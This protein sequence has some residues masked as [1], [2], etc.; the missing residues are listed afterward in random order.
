[1]TPVIGARITGVST[2]TGPIWMGFNLRMEAR[3][4]GAKALAGKAGLG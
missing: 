4:I 2:L 1:V 3:E